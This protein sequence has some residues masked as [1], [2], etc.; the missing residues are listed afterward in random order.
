[1]TRLLPALALLLSLGCAPKA[2]LLEDSQL[3]A[4]LKEGQR[5]GAATFD[6][7]ALDALLTK[8]V[9]DDGL[10]RYDALATDRPALHAY[11][12]AIG[13]ADA[14]TLPAPQQKALLINA[15]NA[16]TL[17]LILDHRPGISSIRE[18]D[19]PWDTP[20]WTLAGHKV[21]LNDIEHGLLRP[22]F[23]DPR[24]HFAVNCAS[25]GCP[26]LRAAAYTADDLDA[27]LDQAA[28]AAL[29]RPRWCKV[30][31]G[32]LHLTKLLEWYGADMTAPDASP[33]ADSLPA[34]IAPYVPTDAA[35]LIAKHGASTP[36]KF[37]DYDWKLN[38]AR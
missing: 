11:L 6:H 14:R 4:Q 21:S 29:A 23:H 16:F 31:G 27:Q 10:V 26:P 8:H 5:R 32:K 7:A 15:Y 2:K 36:I 24:I 28:R 38:D 3:V 12:D 34:W 37:L 18:I 33:R 13:A 1:M 9:T 20:R 35:A 22:M 17:A 25:L 30:E 19:A